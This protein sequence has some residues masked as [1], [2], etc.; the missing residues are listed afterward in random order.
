ME[1]VGHSFLLCRSSPARKGWHRLSLLAGSY[2]QESGLPDSW[3]TN[4]FFGHG[5]RRSFTGPRS[6]KRGNDLRYW[7]RDPERRVVEFEDG[8]R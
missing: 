5:F 7:V 3:E 2:R 6:L 4:L 1:A 8:G